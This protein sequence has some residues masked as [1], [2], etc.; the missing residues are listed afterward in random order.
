MK[1]ICIL[2]GLGS[3]ALMLVLVVAV[4]VGASRDAP[5]EPPSGSTAEGVD[6]GPSGAAQP[7]AQDAQ[8]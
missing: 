4:L 3:L 7:Q 6:A 2:V 1:V 8:Q 5:D